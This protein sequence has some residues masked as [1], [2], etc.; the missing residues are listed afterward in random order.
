MCET[1]WKPPPK[2]HCMFRNCPQLKNKQLPPLQK[3]SYAVVPDLIQHS[4]CLEMD[5]NKSASPTA[6]AKEQPEEPDGPLPGSVSEQEK[7]AST[8]RYSC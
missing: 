5:V 6:A 3:T 8:L 7:K 4:G 1:N 2:F